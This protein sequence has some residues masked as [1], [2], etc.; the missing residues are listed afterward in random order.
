MNMLR[1]APST[2]SPFPDEANW[3]TI[4][5]HSARPHIGNG[6]LIGPGEGRTHRNLRLPPLWYRGR[7]RSSLSITKIKLG[8]FVSA[9][10]GVHTH[11]ANIA[12]IMADNGPVARK[13]LGLYGANKFAVAPPQIALSV[14]VYKAIKISYM[15]FELIAVANQ[16][17]DAEILWRERP[18]TMNSPIKWIMLNPRVRDQDFTLCINSIQRQI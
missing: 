2:S 14:Y 6:Q 15:R 16:K 13:R 12:K 17:P 7:G 10:R 18:C 3:A 4:Q 8:R 9:S 5:R 1:Q 11:N